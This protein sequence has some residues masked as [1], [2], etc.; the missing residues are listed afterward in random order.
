MSLSPEWFR[1]A[2]TVMPGGVNSPVR[3]F[4]AV[5]GSPPFVGSARGAVVTTVDGEEFVDLVASWGALILGHAHPEIV[6]AV[7]EAARRGTS[8]GLPTP[9]EVEL[10]ELICELVPSL[11][12]V[13]MVN[14][15]TEA[16][17]SAVRVARGVTGR[18]GIVKFEGCY[19]GHA[20]SFLVRAGSGAAT[21]GEP[22][23]PGVP[24]STVADTHIARFNDLDSVERAFSEGGIAAVI[25]EPVAGNMGVVPPAPGFLE[26]LRA[27][28]DR[29]GAVLIFD[30]VMTG[31]RVAPGGAQER[32]GVVP[33]LT[34][35]GKVVAGGTPAAVYGGRADLMRQVA[36]DGS[37]YQAGTLAGNPLAVAAGLATLRYLVA[38]PEIYDTLESLGSSLEA[39]LGAALDDH[40]I[41]GCVQ[42]V[43]A[44][45]TVFFGPDEVSSWDEAAKVNRDRFA[46]FFHAAYRRGVLVPPSPFE[47][48]F[49]MDSHR[50]V[51]G[52]MA[53]VL[54]E[55]VEEAG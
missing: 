27:L 53:E 23:S 30:E 13:R 10:A 49:L 4:R 54:V 7:E 44:M 24:A 14:S 50:E 35:L 29:H 17:A 3:A 42:R 18:D 48:M 12:V 38:N 28:C 5:G 25:V 45:L 11:E 32:Y 8:F 1:R 15:G 26:G 2:S 41:P 33:D 31:F 16:T 36:P 47:A 40:G 22:D 9:G 55:A 39:E 20:D 21:F 19:H 46:R 51:A 52:R 37:I 43:G 34:C 6:A